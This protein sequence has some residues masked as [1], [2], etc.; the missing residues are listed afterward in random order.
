VQDD[1]LWACSN[2]TNGGF[3]LGV[4]QDEGKRFTPKMHFCDV[5]GPIACPAGTAVAEVCAAGWPSQRA[6]FGCDGADAG[7]DLAEPRRESC[8][9]R[10]TAPGS[11]W[12]AALAGIAAVLAVLR[13]ARKRA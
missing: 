4:S 10:T 2:E 12:A 6:L 13:R 3:V 7:T 11:S 5:K 1:G 8:D 9:C